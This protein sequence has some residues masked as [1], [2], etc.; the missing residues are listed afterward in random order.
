MMFPY[1]PSSPSNAR[2]VSTFAALALSLGGALAQD[3][4]KPKAPVA[5][6]APSSSVVDADIVRYCAN[7]A[8]SAAEARVAY[9]TKKL[10]ELE[11]RIKQQLE[12][13]ESEE[14]A[15]RDWVAKREALQKTATEDV[16]AIYAKMTAEA[17]A[18][19][20][21]AMDDPIAAGILSKLNPRVASAILGEMVAEKAAKL[22]SLMEGGGAE[23]GK[24]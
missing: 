9:Q 16:V 6:P 5:A 7:L 22:T 4:L 2:V 14:M 13:L 10:T 3:G 24:S 21:A 1:R 11:G 12:R 18:A 8:P 19:Q 20:I 15:A 23:G 17:G